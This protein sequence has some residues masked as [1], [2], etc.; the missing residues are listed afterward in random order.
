MS[1]WLCGIVSVYKVRGGGF[2]T[3]FL[4]KYFTNSV[5]S[6]EFICREKLNVIL[7]IKKAHYNIL[8]TRPP[9]VKTVGISIQLLSGPLMRYQCK[10]SIITNL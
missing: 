7:G 8:K 6:T 5:D 1:S 9:N 2:E 10:G 3:H 4:Q